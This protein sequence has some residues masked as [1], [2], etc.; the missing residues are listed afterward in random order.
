M[1][2]EV[3]DCFM[4]ALKDEKRARNIRGCSLSS[5]TIKQHKNISKKQ[6]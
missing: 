2:K 4:N 6:S 1:N 3:R 5:Q